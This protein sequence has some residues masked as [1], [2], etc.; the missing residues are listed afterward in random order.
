MKVCP[1]CGSELSED[2]SFCPS[3][4]SPL[5]SKEESEGEGDVGEKTVV[6][7]H[8]EHEKEE[9]V[10]PDRPSDT[11]GSVGDATLVMSEASL[12][13]GG[14]DVPASA[15]GDFVTE[16]VSSTPDETTHASADDEGTADD[17][18]DW[19][20]PAAGPTDEWTEEP[21]A[22]DDDFE[23]TAASADEWE[24]EEAEDEFEESEFEEQAPVAAAAA[25]SGDGGGEEK[26]RSYV[27]LIIGLVLLFAAFV[28]ILGAAAGIWWYVANR[29]AETAA[30]NTEQNVNENQE[31]AGEDIPFEDTNANLE[32]TSNADANA[33]ANASPSP[34][35]SP[36][37]TNERATPSPR[38]TRSPSPS[39]SRTVDISRP[40]PG[41]T[42]TP[43]PARTPT[44]VRSTPT[45]N[46]PSRV[47]KGVVNGQAISLPQPAYPSAAR[48]VNARGSVTVAV[49]IDRSGRVIS[50]SA[51]SGHPL[52]RSPAVSAARRARFRPTLLSGQPVEV[53]GT[54]VYNFQ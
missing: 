30:A 13:G 24:E 54:I 1:S 51:V 38:A 50:A 12:P 7:G 37:N 22:A 26:K 49:V 53:S 3:D 17:T 36:A 14:D 16:D 20:A 10:V 43:T 4:G 8:D 45:P 18:S 23:A 32:D 48:A 42:P 47:S 28:V 46:I 15:P 25:D 33:D 11:E 52:L 41:R 21:P 9:T 34:G 5:L 35:R 40:T 2:L 27:G 31:N 6:M 19:V 29:P 39:P 44:P